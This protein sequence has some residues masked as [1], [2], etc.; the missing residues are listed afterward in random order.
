MCVCVWSGGRVG[1][2]LLGGGA[3]QDGGGGG[4]GE[5]GGRT[6]HGD[7][8]HACP[9]NTKQ[10]ARRRATTATITQSAPPAVVAKRA[11]VRVGVERVAHAKAVR[12]RLLPRVLPA[13]PHRVAAEPVVRVAQR[14]DVVVARVRAREHQRHVVRLGA[15]VDEVDDLEVARH[16][17]RELLGVER[18][19][20]VQVDRRRVLQPAR[21]R[22]DGGDDVGVA[23]AD[24]DGDDAGKGLGV[25]SGSARRCCFFVW[26]VEGRRSCKRGEGKHKPASQ[27]QPSERPQR[28]E[29]RAHTDDGRAAAFKHKGGKQQGRP[30]PNQP[31]PEG[32]TS[33]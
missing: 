11:A 23:V 25:F 21:L 16:A 12:H 30:H 5:R 24:A 33:R 13:E 20:G 9:P 15:A 10:R 1:C 3:G 29:T 32:R 17:R 14:D 26:R 18:D 22:L 7:D 27:P 4:G 6:G 28:L 31:N 2:F 19:L 8:D